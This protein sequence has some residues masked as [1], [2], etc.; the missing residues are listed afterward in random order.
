MSNIIL[1]IVCFSVGI[2]LQRTGRFPAA[3][4]AALNGF[5]IHVSLPA[6]ALL[7]IHRLHIDHSLLFTAAMAWLL[8]GAG[9]LFFRTV[10]RLLGLQS[11]T[12]GALMLVGGLG[13]TSFVGLPMIEAYYGKEFL[14]V[15]LIADQLGSFLVLSTLGIVVATVY[16]A[17]D[18]S[19]RQMVRKVILFPPFQALVISFLLIPVPFPDWL[20]TVLQKLGD[21]LT[22]LALASVGFQLRLSHI[23]GEL[24]PL[25]LGL[26]YKLVIGPALLTLLFV[27]VLGG[28]GEVMQVTLFEAAMAP[29]ITAGIIA[30]DH[31]LN[32]PLVTL[33][34]GIGIPLSFLTLPVWWWLL[35]GV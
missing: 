12:I 31:D 6:L 24:K 25:G 13:N 3:T 18:I 33:M 17:G 23:S 1:L 4:P 2:V 9:F 22:P 11:G 16:S 19:S 8:F 10:G 7:H 14:G 29:M 35:R 20:V 5:V 21:T 32:P 28:S 27:G 26:L 34:L 30:V 15:G